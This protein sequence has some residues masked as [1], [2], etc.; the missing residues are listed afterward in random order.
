MVFMHI[1]GESKKINLHNPEAVFVAEVGT[2]SLIS[3]LASLGLFSPDHYFCPYRDYASPSGR[4]L[5]LLG[6]YCSL[7]CLSQVLCCS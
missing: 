5:S 3:T 2:F 1:I 4:C 6:S 7:F